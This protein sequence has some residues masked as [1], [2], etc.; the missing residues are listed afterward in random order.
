MAKTL[1]MVRAFREADDAT[2]IVLMGYYNPIYI[3]G[4]DKFLAD[5]KAAGVDGLI[6]VDLPPE[7]DEELCLPALKARAQ[8]H[9]PRDADHRRQAPA[10]GA[11][12]HLGLRLLRL[13]HRHHRRRRARPA[14]GARRRSRASS[15]TPRCRSRS[16]SASGPANS[17]RAIAEGAD[18]VVVGSALVDAVKDSLADGKATPR[19][20]AAVADLVRQLADGVRGAK[21]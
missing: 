6:I 8:L 18:G 12:E 7:E 14:A 2:P 5:A 4:V 10:G 16:A 19:T 20:V 17:A 13:D 11:A 15:A 9:P 1:A 3:C 21:R